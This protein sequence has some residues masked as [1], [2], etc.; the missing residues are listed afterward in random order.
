MKTSRVKNTSLVLFGILALISFFVPISPILGS[1]K[2]TLT[3]VSTVFP[4]IGGLASMPCA[5]LFIITYGLFKWF[6]TV[7]ITTTGI[8]LFFATMN[9][10][11]QTQALTNNSR[12]ITLARLFLQVVVPMICMA[13]FVAHPVG[14]QAFV[15][16][17]FW[18]VPVAL[19]TLE[20]LTIRNVFF[21]ALSSTFIAHAIGT[22]L[23]IYMVP[24][25]AEQWITLIPVTLAERLTMAAAST[26]LFVAIK[27]ASSYLNALIVKSRENI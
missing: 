26:L 3:G 1:F 7:T 15:Y 8:P 23:W 14:R 9:W 17:W 4:L 10:N 18:L 21:T 27:T 13:L 5:A 2:F 16:S 20:K 6:T 24:M 19:Y 11:I 22:I 25:T 12:T